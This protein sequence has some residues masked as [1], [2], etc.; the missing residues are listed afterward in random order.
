M[1][2]IDSLTHVTSDGR[3][4]NTNCDA[5]IDRLLF[6]M[7]EN[8]IDKAVVVALADYI[9]NEFVLEICRKHPKRFI[10]GAS[11]NPCK[12]NNVRE[13]KLA[14]RSELYEHSFRI[15]KLH[16]RLNMYDP[17]DPRCLAILDELSSWDRKWF[18]WLD[19]LLYYPGGFRHRSV[20][21][22][23]HEIVCRY[24]N[25]FFVLL[26]GGGSRV[27]SLTEAMQGCTNVFIDISYTLCRYAQSSI[28][29]DLQ[30]L[31]NTFDRRIIFGSDFP[32]ISLSTAMSVMRSLTPNIAEDKVLNV[33][34]MNLER[35][36][37]TCDIVL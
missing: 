33:L 23:L 8:G 5:S 17:L 25:L 20:V 3:W 18:V 30:F 22:T 13:V 29:Y 2:V 36:L 15:I 11:F 7:A 9:D 31:I 19:T 21:D 1:M 14:I 12:Y 6:E 37:T 10:P 32:E 28:W 16:P 24:P 4:F 35:L 26:H 34:G 27:L